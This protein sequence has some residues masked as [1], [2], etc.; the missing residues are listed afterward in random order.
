M[1]LLYNGQTFP[2]EELKLPLSN[3]AFQ[4]NDGFFETVMVVNGQLQFWTD[5]LDRMQEASK[6][7][8]LNLPPYFFS[9]A[10]KNALLKLAAENKSL[11]YGRLKLKIWRAGEGLY[12]PQANNIDWLATVEPAVLRSGVYLNIGICQNI[13]AV[14]S[15]L[16]HFKGP[17]APLYV[18]ASQ[19]KQTHGYDDM[20]LLNVNGYIAELTSSN[21]FW[22]QHDILYTPAL[23]TGCIN[24]IM[25][26][27]ILAYCKAEGIATREVESTVEVI[28]QADSVFAGNVTGI[29][30]IQS[31][32]GKSLYNKS[33]LHTLL[34]NKFNT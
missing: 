9:E 11:N 30:Q 15:P 8:H 34:I 1:Q 32:D 17:N 18:L 26:R 14:H 6:A 31:I 29:R 19:E 33:S 16:S 28:I 23:S 2:E 3:R 13:R 7:L 4:Y 25:R 27:R 12:T 5:H 10:F 24:G 21:I 22:V 20:L